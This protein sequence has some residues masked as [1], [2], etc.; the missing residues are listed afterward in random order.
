MPN[1]IHFSNYY[2]NNPALTHPSTADLY[3]DEVQFEAYRM[4]GEHIGRQAVP[5]VNVEGLRG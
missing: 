5:M 4:L 2:K 3:F 1:S